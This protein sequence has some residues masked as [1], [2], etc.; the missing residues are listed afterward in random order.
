[1][2]GAV[3]PHRPEVVVNAAA[4]TAVDACESDRRSCLPRQRRRRALAARGVRCDAGAHL[5]QIST[6]Y[7]FDG[8]LDRPYREDDATNPHLGVR[9]VEARGRAAPPAREATI[10]RTSWLCGVAGGN[11]VKTV[12]RI[13]RTPAPRWRSSADQ[14]GCPT[15][16]ADLVVAVRELAGDAG[17][18]A[19][20][21]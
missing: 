6:D 18:P 10:V 2:H 11:M 21:T 17:T 14:R 1:M 8:T 9:H 20:S 5:V 3:E 13:A 19:C 15:F 16:T 4:W 12:L 7:V